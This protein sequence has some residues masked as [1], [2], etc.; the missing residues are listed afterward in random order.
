MATLQYADI[1]DAVLLTQEN[2]I[3]EGAFLDLQ[4]DI[5]DHVAV[6]ELWKGRQKKFDGGNDWQFQAQ[7]AGNGST[8]AVGLFE[9]DGTALADTMIE[10][11][12]QPRHVNACYIYD[13]R[14]K[15]FQQGGK[16]IVD[17]VETRYTA[18]MVDFYDYLEAVLW[19]CPLASDTKTPHGI[20]Y[21]VTKGTSGQEGFYGL[22]PTGYTAIGRAHI[23]SSAQARWRNW[24]ADYATVS[25][26]DLVRK[27]DNAM[28]ATQF[29]SVVEHAQPDVGSAKT[30]IY[31]NRVTALLLKELLASQNMNLGSDLI[32]P[33]P[34]LKGNPITYVPKLDDDTTNPV[35]VLDW[36]WLAIGVLS[37]WE[38]NLSKPYPVPGKSKVRR[39]DLDCTLELVCTNLRKQMVFAQIV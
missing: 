29:R 12:M 4:T 32:G 11:Y 39:V 37:G 24:A 19:A 8:R 23:L 20:S 7:I 27:I 18:M 36:R 2:L 26:E 16:A 14:E 21:W 31:A 34:L 38:E 17:L 15:S 6:R 9:T 3:K 10:G 35:Y 30:G 25:T 5:T 13:Q 28:M 22:D 33:T 1:D